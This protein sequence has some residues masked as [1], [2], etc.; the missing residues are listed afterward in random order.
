MGYDQSRDPYVSFTDPL[1]GGNAAAS[2]AARD[3]YTLTNSMIGAQELPTYGR[4]MRV[5]LASN[6]VV[7]L[8]IVCVP[9]GESV[10]SNTRTVLV[11]ATE[12]LPFAVRRIVSLNAGATV[13]TGVSIDIIT[14]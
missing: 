8:T 13:P 4:G 14:E 1:S 7:P 10:D 5:R 12:S 2:G 11:D 9:I 6:A 3:W